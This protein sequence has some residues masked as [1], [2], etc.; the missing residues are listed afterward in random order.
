MKLL[1]VVPSFGLGG[2]EKVICTLI[3]H[4]TPTYQHS[5]LALDNNTQAGSWLQAEKVNFLGFEKPPQRRKF[6]LALASALR[7]VRPDLLMTYTWGATDALWLGRLVGIQHI[8]HSEHGFNVDESRGTLWKR[9]M[10]RLPVYH[11]ASKVIVV[12]RELQELLQRKYLLTTDRLV[13][14]P[15]GIDTSYYAP[16]LEERQQVRRKLGFTDAHT[17]VGF[18][19][20]LDPIKNFDLLLHIF[21]SCVQQNPRVRLLIV[22]DGA[23]K[24]RLV[25][26]CHHKGI[27]HSV[28]FTGQQEHVLPY[29]C[30]MDVFL[31]TSL[32]EQMPM[33]ILEAMAVGVPVIATRVGEIPHIIDDGINGFVHRLDDPV[34][35]CPSYPN[36]TGRAWGKQRVR[37]L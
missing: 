16:D 24:K 11:L 28:V 4:T 5:V 27:H 37:R 32:R 1:H 12:S 2:M 9:D 13:R 23:E 20:R 22:G 29:L 30:A 18:S 19:G 25:T 14:I 15:N 17:V 21:S 7:Y 3:K 36:H 31:L 34:A 8:V 10:I 35:D 33:T 26:L 6:F